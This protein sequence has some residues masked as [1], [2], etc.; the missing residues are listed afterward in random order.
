MIKQNSRV[1]IFV[2]QALK[3]LES[4]TYWTTSADEWHEDIQMAKEHLKKAIKKLE[5]DR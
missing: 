4:I 3:K 5:E 1:W 2:E